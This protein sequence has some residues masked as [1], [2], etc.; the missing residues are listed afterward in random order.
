M[1]RY[2]ICG[3]NPQTNKMYFGNLAITPFI[4]AGHVKL[5]LL[6]PKTGKVEEEAVKKTGRRVSFS[7]IRKII[8]TV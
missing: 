7:E 5:K 1:A 4:I 2:A 3:V 8:K 6:S